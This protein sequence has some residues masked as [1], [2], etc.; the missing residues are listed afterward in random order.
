MAETIKEDG[1]Y[2]IVDTPDYKI[3]IEKDKGDVRLVAEYH[4]QTFKDYI[5]TLD[6][7]IFLNACTKYGKDK[8]LIEFS[9]LINL[10]EYNEEAQNCIEIFKEIVKECAVEKINKI[11]KDTELTD[12][13]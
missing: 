8:S 12:V 3:T 6:D 11:I 1:I 5:D 2:T 9:D 10:D 13:F 7:E 4:K